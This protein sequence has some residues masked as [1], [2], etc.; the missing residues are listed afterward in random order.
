ME[1]VGWAAT[2]IAGI[3]VVGGLVLGVRA[4]P[5]LKRYLQ[6]RRM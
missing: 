3:A 2:V 1:K 5:D 4:V 6:M